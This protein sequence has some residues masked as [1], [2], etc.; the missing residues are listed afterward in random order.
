MSE[1]S[2]LGM[3][4][5]QSS[6]PRRQRRHRSHRR[7]GP[8]IALVV[9]IL[10]AVGAFLGGRAIIDEFRTVPDYEGSGTGSIYV[11]IDVGATAVDIAQ[12]LVKADV[13]KSERAFISAAKDDPRSRNIQ[14][15]TYR[16]HKHM[17][18]TAALAL[19]L[20]PS[21][22][23]GQVTIPEGMSVAL[24]L[25]RLAQHTNISLTDLQ[26]AAKKPAQLGLPA[27]AGDR[28]EGFL[29][30]ATYF[31][32]QSATATDVL[33]MMVGQFMQKVATSSLSDRH[34][35]L[36][37]YQ[38]LT[39]ASLLETEGITTDFGKIARV[40]DNRL[41]RH[42]PLQLDSTI[43]FALGRNN[44]RVSEA[45]TKINSPYNTYRH[46]G[47]PPTPIANPGLDAI[48]A[49]MHPSG[50]PWLYFVKMDRAGD[51]FFTDDPVAFA[52]Q[53]AKSKAEGIY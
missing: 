21:A 15:A 17:S 5:E 35:G 32:P 1:L 48:Q 30:P 52:K 42:M 22:R 39:V 34:Q 24:T 3:E 43:N 23:V 40:I 28:L 20:D 8:A 6:R 46:A 44:V 25:R 27:F 7:R 10:L 31:I 33:R 47:L 37:P 19:M 45:Q 38:V 13:V 11:E 12:S 18:A 36:T 9:V 26:A 14:A 51:S 41:A 50:G 16:M 2:I 53:K 49:A 29:F 4:D